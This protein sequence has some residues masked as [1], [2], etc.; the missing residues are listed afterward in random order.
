MALFRRARGLCPACGSDRSADVPERDDKGKVNKAKEW[1]LTCCGESFRLPVDSAWWISFRDP[2]GKYRRRKIGPDRQAAR[3]VLAKFKTSIVEGRYVDPKETCKTTLAELL[4]R[5]FDAIR[6]TKK[7]DNWKRERCLSRR[8][9]DFF[10]AGLR[11]D[12]IGHPEIEAYRLERMNQGKLVAT[13]NRELAMLGATLSW[14]VRQCM[15]TERPQIRM[16]DPKNERV[17]FITR[18]EAQRLLSASDED[19]RDLFQAALATGMR[20]GELLAM[21]WDW[22]DLQNGQISLPAK[23]TKNGRARHVPISQDMREV[24]ER[25][26]DRA[27]S[28]LP[29]FHRKGRAIPETT[30]QYKFDLATDKAGIEDLHPNDLRHTCAS[31]LVMAGVDLYTVA[32]IL[33]HRNLKMTQRYAHLAPGHL[34]KAIEHTSLGNGPE[35]EDQPEKAPD[36]DSDGHQVVTDNVIVLES[37]AGTDR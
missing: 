1:G 19:F 28:G 23:A 3:R 8:L 5:Y 25:A 12:K 7:P 31:W 30:V 21:R 10:G 13:C 24:L 11:I 15:L 17:R 6:P 27:E 14:A 33:G 35:P 16:P 2:A 22:I 4:D 29:V 9:L 32:T 26:R 34:Q 20:R 18:E 36:R 37:F